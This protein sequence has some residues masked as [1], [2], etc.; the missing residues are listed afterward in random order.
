MTGGSKAIWNWRGRDDDAAQPRGMSRRWR[1][2]VQCLVVAAIGT[3]LF[4]VFRR[5]V[6]GLVAFC[7][8]GLILAAGLFIPPVFSLL[9]GLGKMLGNWARVGLTYLLL[10]LIF[11]IWFTPARLVLKL[12]RRDPM[13]RAFPTGLN[14]YWVSRPPVK[15]SDRYRDQF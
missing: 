8:A 15:S 3:V 2:V 12:L 1:A 5:H 14:T 7:L 6:L 9:E 11:F 10:G 13:S 4:V